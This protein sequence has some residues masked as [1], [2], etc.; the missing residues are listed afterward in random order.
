[1]PIRLLV[2]VIGYVVVCVAVYK[3]WPQGAPDVVVATQ[4]IA[5]AA[6]S[7]PLETTTQVQTTTQTGTVVQAEEPVFVEPVVATTVVAEVKSTEDADAMERA[8]NLELVVSDGPSNEETQAR[9]ISSADRM[10]LL[11][12]WTK[13]EECRISRCESMDL[14]SVGLSFVPDEIKDLRRLNTLVVGKRIIDIVAL[15]GMWNLRNLDLNESKVSE[16]SAI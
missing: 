6:Q 7:Q 2:M 15:K 13:I 12:V 5:P 4:Q 14:S 3:L 8:K 16:L 9:L 10:A 1:M 11:E